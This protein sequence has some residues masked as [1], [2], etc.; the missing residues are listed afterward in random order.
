MPQSAP[1]PSSDGGA[2]NSAAAKTAK[3]QQKSTLKDAATP[4]GTRKQGGQKADGTQTKTPSPV[5]GGK[6]RAV[7]RPTEPPLPEV[8]K[9]LADFQSAPSS[10]LR[11]FGQERHTQTKAIGRLIDRVKIEMD[12]VDDSDQEMDK[13]KKA[14]KS[15]E[16][17]LNIRKGYSESKGSGF[18]KAYHETEAW[19]AMDPA[20]ALDFIPK[21]MSSEKARAQLA[22]AKPQVF[23]TELSKAN[24]MRIGFDEKDLDAE[25]VGI[26]SDRVVDMCRMETVESLPGALGEP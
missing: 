22:V 26:I 13:L 20:V 17:M 2:P 5:D 14:K 10:H 12:K 24:M 25:W 19:A 15:L 21:W 8:A 3:A 7:G 11:F 16:I 1:A 9:M 23:W 4:P 18:L 6:K